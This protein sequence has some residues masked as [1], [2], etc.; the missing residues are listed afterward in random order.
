MQRAHAEDGELVRV[1][2]RRLREAKGKGEDVKKGPPERLNSMVVGV[3]CFSELWEL[4]R[5]HVLGFGA[6]GNLAREVLL[7]N[8]RSVKRG[9]FAPIS[10]GF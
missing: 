9:L 8:A 4:C 6:D 2:E 1:V 3:K 10:K 5:P 7:P